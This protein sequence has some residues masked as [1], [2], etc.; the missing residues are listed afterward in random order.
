MKIGD[1]C[2]IFGVNR[3][4]DECLLGA[5]AIVDAIS[6]N[7]PYGNNVYKLICTDRLL[8]KSGRKDLW[9]DE[10]QVEEIR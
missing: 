1:V 5:I 9:L 6:A 7:M 3:E 10:N 2:R 8:V 4:E